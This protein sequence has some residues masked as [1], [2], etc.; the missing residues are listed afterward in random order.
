MPKSWF[1]L[2]PPLS[3]ITHWSD[4][5]L[6]RWLLAGCRRHLPGCRRMSSWGYLRSAMHQQCW[7]LSMP[8]PTGSGFSENFLTLFRVDEAILLFLGLWAFAEEQQNM[9]GQRC[10]TSSPFFH[11]KTHSRAETQEH[12][13]P[14]DLHWFEPS[15]GSCLR[16]YQRGRLLVRYYAR[17]RGSLPRTHPWK[18]KASPYCHWFVDAWGR[19]CRSH[20]TTS[21]YRWRFWYMS[22]AYFH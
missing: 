19:C 18:Q 14:A 8:L 21:L 3:P 1:E 7:K 11:P 12:G 17:S 10:R 15:C 9:L 22:W 16:F 6:S 13:V 5:L 4:L 2:H 20:W